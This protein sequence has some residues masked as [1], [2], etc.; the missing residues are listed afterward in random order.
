M[1]SFNIKNIFVITKKE[2]WNYF[3]GP[4]AYIVMV[5]FLL[6]W[7]FLFFR[8]VFLVGE[9]SLRILFNF[10]PWLFLLLVPAITMGSISQE[11]S[12]GTLEFLLTRPLKDKEL[13]V[14][15][16]LAAVAFAALTLLF[17]FPIAASFGSFG[18][19]DWG[20]VFG[21]YLASVFLA[22]V[23]IALGVFI[24]SLFASQISALL[25]SVAASFFLV[26]AGFEIVTAS[27]PLFLASFFE[28]LSALSHFDSMSRGVVDLRDLWYFL[29]AIL[30]F[31]SLAYLQL[32]KRRFGN[33]KSLYRSYKIGILLFIGIALLTNVVGSR[34]PGR[35][36]LT[37]DRL[38]TLTDSTKKTLSSL[39]DV[40]NITL[41]AS[42]E[43]PAQLQPVLRDVKDTLRDYQTFGKGNIVVISKNP[44]G[45][46]Q[47]A[48]EAGSLGVREVQFNVVGQE[49]FKLQNGYLGL[50][51][52]YAGKSEAIPFI[53]DTSDLEY[54]L[55][56]FI[57]QLTT[58]EK[59][60]IVF[61]S[62]HGEKN[63]FSDY[64]ALFQELQKQFELDTVTMDSDT[65]KNT[66]DNG[67]N[68]EIPKDAA[69][70]V[71]AG[72]TSEIGEK[73]Q[74]AIKDHLESGKAALFLID[75][76]NVNPQFLSVSPN[77]NSFS[78]FLKS[79]G[80]DVRPDLVYDFRSNK[81]VSFGGGFV[82]FLLPY[83]FWARVIASD[84]SPVTVRL[85]SIVLPWGSSIALNETA[86]QEKGLTA[87]T[88]FSTTQFGGRQTGSFSIDPQTKPSQENLESQIVAVS[89]A[90]EEADSQP[91]A[92]RMVIVGDSDF[93]S[94]Q[95][96]QNSPENLAFGMEALSWLSQEE[97]LA[98]I[99]I[100]NKIERKLLF[101]NQTQIALVK[102]GNMLLAFLL[103]A[104]FGI[105][106]L[107]RR[108]NLRKFTY[109]SRL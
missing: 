89:I 46:P 66:E 29:S 67:T 38:Y 79:Y 41:F 81:T 49:E 103:P 60:K 68:K 23:L 97:S 52:S 82:N 42:G 26:I 17:I 16:F 19:L 50:A 9:A 12:E 8:N 15:K 54:Q 39:N 10:L 40:V 43:L 24:S 76:V 91:V 51:V 55:T 109:S 95:F 37:Q 90:P 80:V 13:L 96:V 78:D 69:V 59:K 94:D 105:F 4:T 85:E 35:I 107:M 31:L 100:K 108:R 32:L 62:G 73:A 34:I 63:I 71:I 47:I 2:L 65:D 21:Q 104:G 84:A 77:Q 7:E 30:I 3:D 99:Q 72:P 61:L 18:N 1:K 88:L 93:L 64:R 102:Y 22:S 101:E 11:K 48:Q 36:D 53:Q 86:L 57:K 28:R 44:S 75:A 87:T 70:L 83:P 74:S 56:S 5:V 14:G 27:L 58:T 6:L 92:A 45:N 20:I 25:V 98:G 106:R 33:R